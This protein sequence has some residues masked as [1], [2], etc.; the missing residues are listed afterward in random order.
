MRMGYTSRVLIILGHPVEGGKGGAAFSIHRWSRLLALYSR[1]LQ[2]SPLPQ[3]LELNGNGRSDVV[4]LR[5]AGAAK[6]EDSPL[7]RGG[8][9][10]PTPTELHSTITLVVGEGVVVEELLVVLVVL[11]SDG[12]VLMTI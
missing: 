7:P 1:S 3:S 8:R 2:Y 11:R 6:G 10:V 4:A 12:V 5:A 9:S